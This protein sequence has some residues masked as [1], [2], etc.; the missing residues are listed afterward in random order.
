MERLQQLDCAASLQTD[1]DGR[2][3]PT[4][5]VLC[6][7]T[8]PNPPGVSARVTATDAHFRFYSPY[9]PLGA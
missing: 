8:A 3:F 7:N 5:R 2:V 4:K 6:P 9:V 1:G